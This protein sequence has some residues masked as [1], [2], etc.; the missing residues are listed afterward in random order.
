M[1]DDILDCLPAGDIASVFGENASCDTLGDP[2]FTDIE[3]A[4]VE[5][6]DEEG[7]NAN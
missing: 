5:A 6:V 1:G 2:G 7:C 4:A 3:L